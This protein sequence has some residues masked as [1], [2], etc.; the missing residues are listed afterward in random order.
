MNLDRIVEGF[1]D[2]QDRICTGLE[3]L[4]G[5]SQ[6]QEDRWARNEGGG[7]RS[8][9][10]LDGDL[11]EKGGVNFS[12]V[13]GPMPEKIAKRLQLESGVHFHATG[14]SIVLHAKHPLVP[15]IHMNVRYFET[16]TG[17]YWF[18][19]GID[20]TPIYIDQEQAIWFH[21]QLK[22]ICDRFSPNYYPA[23]KD[24]ADRYFF[25][26]HRN[27]TRG[28]GGIFFDHLNGEDPDEKARLFD[29]VLEV[30]NLFVPV[31]AYLAQKNRQLPFTDRHQAFQRLRRSR[32]VEFNLIWDAGTRF[33]LE[34]DGRTESILM[35]MPPEAAWTYQYEPEPDSPEA[36]TL[37]LLRPMDWL[38]LTH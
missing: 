6:F 17:K 32:Y 2:L 34:T 8:R 12:H 31:Y 35:S 24:W 23:F 29:F 7:G 25:L 10:I 28:I 15:I 3:A 9:V 5:L 16:E 27:E 1:Q 13:H 30:G 33:G 14:V 22:D 36:E 4:D 21:Q 38:G 19:G 37:G 11:I 26:K 18:G 20:V